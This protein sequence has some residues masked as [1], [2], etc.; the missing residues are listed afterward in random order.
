MGFFVILFLKLLT[1]SFL[2]LFIPAFIYISME[3]ALSLSQGGREL[4]TRYKSVCIRVQ[5][6][7]IALYSYFH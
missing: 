7:C 1:F 4:N 3:I 2:S 6:Y 5:S